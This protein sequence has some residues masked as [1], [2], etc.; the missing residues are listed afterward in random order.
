MRVIHQIGRYISVEAS[1]VERLRYCYQLDGAPEPSAPKPY[2]HPIRTPNGIE[3]TADA[4]LDHF[5]HRGLWFTWKYVNGVN[6]WEE[7]QE[8]VGRQVTLVPPTI[9]STTDTVRWTSE[10]EWRDKKDG[11]EMTRIAEQRRIALRLAT[12]GALVMDWHIKQK[13]LENVLLDRTPFGTWGGYGGLVVRM[14]QA[15]QKQRILLSDGTETDHPT[16]QP[17]QW[18]GIEGKLDT[19]RGNAAAFVFLPSPKNRRFPEPF[20]GNAKAFYNFFG[21]APLFHEPLPL[22]AGETLEHAVRVLILP[23][24]IEAAE[25]NGYY[26]E[27]AAQETKKYSRIAA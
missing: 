12:N 22:R 26:E 15:L 19:G 17:Y 5:W 9:E 27:W 20:Y 7:N 16:G 10:I 18:G 1:G 21:P 23:R 8:I 14:T 13:P 3:L 2:C 6:Y 24:L 4:P 25:V 11:A